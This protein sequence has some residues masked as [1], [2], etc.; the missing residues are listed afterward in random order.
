MAIRKT[1]SRRIVVNG[2]AFRW[3]I[4]KRATYNQECFSGGL[5]VAV[6]SA[7]DSGAV[8]LILTGLSHPRSYI[9]NKKAPVTP[10]DVAT[11]IRQAMQTG[12]KPDKAG[13]QFQIRVESST[14]RKIG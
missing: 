8:L 12:W 6:E 13:P 4:R 1:G 11:W 5:Q 9:A 2:V 7:D 3:R 10:L 14:A